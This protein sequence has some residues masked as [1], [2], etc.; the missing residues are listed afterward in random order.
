[1]K[2]VRIYKDKPCME[3]GGSTHRMQDGGD[4]TPHL[5]YDEMGNAYEANNYNDHLA[6]T[7]QGFFHE[8]VL[9]QMF[10][11]IKK[12]YG[13]DIALQNES[14]DSVIQNR[15]NMFKDHIANNTMNIIAQEEMLDFENQMQQPMMNAN[16][17]QPGGDVMSNPGY[18]GNPMLNEY[19]NKKYM[20]NMLDNT[21]MSNMFNTIGNTDFSRHLVGKSKFLDNPLGQEIKQKYQDM[22]KQYRKMQRNP[23]YA[24]QQMMSNI[25]QARYG[26]EYDENDFLPEM[27]WAGAFNP[28]S[29]VFNT[30]NPIM[31]TNMA[32][33]RNVNSAPSMKNKRTLR[34]DDGLHQFY[35]DENGRKIE[36]VF[37]NKG[38]ILWTKVD[39]KVTQRS[40]AWQNRNKKSSGQDAAS[41]AQVAKSTGTTATTTN[42]TTDNTDEK[43]IT[44]GNVN[45]NVTTTQN[46]S[47]NNIN[48]NDATLVD[49]PQGRMTLKQAEDLGLSHQ[50]VAN[51]NQTNQNQTNQGN[52]QPFGTVFPNVGWGRRGNLPFMYN[53]ADTRLPEITTRRALLPGN[54]IKKISFTHGMPVQGTGYGN[55]PITLNNTQANNQGNAGSFRN[56]MADLLLQTPGLRNVG[57]KMVDHTGQGFDASQDPAL[58]QVANLFN[59]KPAPVNNAPYVSPEDFYQTLTNPIGSYTDTPRTYY[60]TSQ[61]SVPQSL[62]FT[63]QTNVASQNTQQ[64]NFTPMMTREEIEA[65]KLKNPSAYAQAQTLG[66][67]IPSNVP[68][69]TQQTQT[70]NQGNTLAKPKTKQT[71]NNVQN[72]SS[73]NTQRQTSN[74]GTKQNSSAFYQAKI[75]ELYKQGPYNDEVQKYIDLRDK[76]EAAEIA[77]AKK[78]KWNAAKSAKLAE[79]QRRDKAIQKHQSS[80]YN[81]GLRFGGDIDYFQEGG[82]TDTMIYPSEDFQYMNEPFYNYAEF[83]YPQE[84]YEEDINNQEMYDEEMYDDNMIIPF[85]NIGVDYASLVMPPMIPPMMTQAAFGME[86][87]MG[88]EYELTDEEIEAIIQNG[89]EVEFL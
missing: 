75:D 49:T 9:N 19:L 71:S 34:K 55:Q 43:E 69:N 63:Q 52:M 54:R 16:Y 24:Y 31:N 81:R 74:A 53:P 84:T 58:L 27:Q 14:T 66:Q 28:G 68:Q 51:Q 38:N 50:I 8:D 11:K 87:Q 18:V 23:L 46:T 1:M 44:Q 61:N 12:K 80:L 73:N 25:P 6:Y 67:S 64:G 2:R 35:T 65:D 4:F 72:K 21:I 39:G 85:Q 79:E 76:A 59:N 3:C 13:G 78:D 20:G 82:P 86:Y 57:A 88:G 37:D 22:N 42:T 48:V 33:Y 41:Q 32:G 15:N 62:P 70:S 83:M 89:G 40:E 29:P 5:M 47:S 60:P 10:P 36:K 26:M 30:Q 56:K 17:F 7:N 45:P 77:K